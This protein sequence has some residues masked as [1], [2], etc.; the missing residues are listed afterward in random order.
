MGRDASSPGIGARSYR[1]RAHHVRYSS[2]SMDGYVE[3]DQIKG[4]P[5]R[6][7]FLHPGCGR[8]VV[9]A[10]IAGDRPFL[11][12]SWSSCSYFA[13]VSAFATRWGSS[14]DCSSINRS[15]AVQCATACFIPA[16]GQAW[17]KQSLQEPALR[18][19]VMVMICWG[20]S[21]TSTQ[22]TA[23]YFAF[24]IAFATRCGSSLDCSNINRS[25]AVECATVCF[26]QASGQAWYEP[27]LPEPAL[28]VGIMRLLLCLCERLCDAM[29]IKSRLQQ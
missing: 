25:R 20:I 15:R 26:I 10:V 18:V 23:S 24:V 6:Y 16:A 9:R 28:R 13:F 12:A 5:M 2:C 11:S 1:R 8:G 22:G 29:R 4:R 21:S 19:G 7:R 27:S 14:L 17:Y 3:S